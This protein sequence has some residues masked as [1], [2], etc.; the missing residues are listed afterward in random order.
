[1]LHKIGDTV[2]FRIKSVEEEH[3]ETSGVCVGQIT[4]TDTLG[5]YIKVPNDTLSCDHYVADWECLYVVGV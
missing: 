1:M 5:H 2:A 4:H 3:A